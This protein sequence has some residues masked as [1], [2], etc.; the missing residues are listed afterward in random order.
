M[1]ISSRSVPSVATPSTCVSPRVKMALPC[2]RGSADVSIQMG[3][4][5]RVFRPSARRSSSRMRR[6]SSAFSTRSK[7]VLMRSVR[8]A[9]SS[10]SSGTRSVM[11]ASRIALRFAERSFFF[12]VSSA[13][14]RPA[15]RAASV[16]SGTSSLKASFG[17]GGANFSLPAASRI[18]SMR[19][20]TACISRCPNSMA[21][22]R[23]S[24]STSC[25]PA[26]TIMTASRVPA[27]TISRVERPSCSTVGFTTYSPST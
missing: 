1:R 21:P 25:A 13:S 7:A 3:R 18:L 20:M 6:R 9:A 22:T 16:I 24:S 27:T 10:A 26:S 4:T 15:A 19:S 12:G 23:S 5:V 8:S 17:S 11:R 14:R 2:A